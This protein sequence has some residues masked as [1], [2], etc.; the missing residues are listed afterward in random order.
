MLVLD[1]PEPDEIERDPDAP[2]TY[3]ILPDNG[4]QADVRYGLYA[5]D[6]VVVI[7]PPGFPSE[8]QP[9]AF[10]ADVAKPIGVIARHRVRA[11]PAP[12]VEP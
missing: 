8:I 6:Q 4:R 12:E 2:R 1:D 5:E 3:V 9:E 10:Y 7:I 11:L